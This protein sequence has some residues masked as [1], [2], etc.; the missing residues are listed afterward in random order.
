VFQ[1]CVGLALA[2][3]AATGA[4]LT[5]SSCAKKWE[6]A[7]KPVDFQQAG[8]SAGFGGQT[9]VTSTTTTSTV[10]S[11][12][13]ATRTLQL[14]QSNGN[15]TA[16]KAGPE[17]AN[18][19]QLKIGDLVQATVAEELAVDV[20][21]ANASLSTSNK[22]VLVRSPNGGPLIN[23]DTRTLTAALVSVDLITYTVTLRLADG[24]VKAVNVNP[25]INLAAFNPGDR[26]SVQVSE[27]RTFVV[28]KQPSP[29]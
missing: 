7:P 24:T 15:T 2:A 17:V 16:Y 21:A 8:G 6:L 23:V 1:K 19:D 26:V 22:V 9:F 20:A 25:N 14:K 3:A 11:I 12:D 18:F 5:L 13:A 10:V 29:P 27:A 28:E 4:L